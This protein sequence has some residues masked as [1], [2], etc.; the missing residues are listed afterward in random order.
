MP[1]IGP[2]SGSHTKLSD[3]SS[4]LIAGSNITISSGSGDNVTIAASGGG[5][6]ISF[7]GSTSNGVLTYKD[8]DEASVESNLTYN[9]TTL[10]LTG[11]LESKAN[12]HEGFAAKLH[13]DQS[14]SGHVLKLLADGNGSG[15]HILEMEDGDG[16]V[17][18]RARADGRFGFG[19][20]GVSSMGA[21]TFV[22]GIDGGHT[23]DIAISKRLQHLGDSNTFMDFPAADKI[24]FQAGGVDMLTMVESSNE[25]QVLVLSDE[26]PSDTNFFVS[27]SE[28]G[29]NNEGVSIFGG[30]LVV[31]GNLYGGYNHHSEVDSLHLRSTQN[32]IGGGRVTGVGTD[33][34]LFISGTAGSNGQPGSY[35]A[36]V[37]QG[38]LIVS[39][40]FKKFGGEEDWLDIQNYSFTGQFQS[41]W[42]RGD[43][44]VFSPGANE[45]LTA[46][47]LYYLHTDGT[48]N[49]AD[50]SSV[51]TGATAK[52]G[53]GLGGP[54]QYYG[55]FTKGYYRIPSGQFNGTFVTGSA[56]YV[57]E[58]TAGQFDAAAPSSAGE[59]VRV[60]GYAL[61]I[62]SSSG[63]VLIDFD[64]MKGYQVV[65]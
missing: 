50:A 29:K 22:V 46:G 15:T 42:G 44:L 57:S 49:L 9:G 38:D 31:S 6:G 21:G 59:Y 16:D 48:W 45:M 47:A 51:S 39:G 40:G 14:D 13:N 64:P 41:G 12:V 56:V 36:A 17:L 10:I 55:V 35:G 54:S 30:D 5:G 28:G 52:L 58:G 25:G 27:G 34:V 20:N 65:S 26:A 24:N 19:P 33:V 32:I 18:F 53:I 43:F 61:S 60:V 7:D 37:S 3:G 4:F 1:L 63:D 23:S 11:A 2:V 8:S 62:D